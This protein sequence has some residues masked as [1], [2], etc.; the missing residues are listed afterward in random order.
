MKIQIMALGRPREAFIA[1]GVEHYQVRLKPLLPIEWVYLPD[2]NRGKNLSEER[3]KEL[4]G[5]EFLKRIAPQDTLFLL[6]ERGRQ[7][8]SGELSELIYSSLG[9]GQGK[10][11]FLVGGPYGTSPELQKRGNVIISLSKMTFTH[12]MALLLL[13]EQI[14]RTAMIHSGS[15]YHHQ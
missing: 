7:M 10:L 15:K 2:I 14:Y 12:E 5:R 4:E 1:G 6:D 9:K 8:T 13:S 3:R 11:I